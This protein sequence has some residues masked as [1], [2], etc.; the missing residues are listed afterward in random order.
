M[1]VEPIADERCPDSSEGDE[2][3][4]D[5]VSTAI[6]MAVR[7]A[8]SSGIDIDELAERLEMPHDRRFRLLLWQQ[9]ERY[10]E[11]TGQHLRI[12]RN[13][14]VVCSPAE[15][16]RE[17]EKRW[18]TSAARSRRAFDLVQPLLGS[19]DIEARAKAERFLNR[20][21][22]EQA[23][24]DATAAAHARDQSLTATIRAALSPNKEG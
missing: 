23:G 9:M 19:T 1:S 24:L 22:S 8:A 20:Q 10:R 21:V 14:V 11:E 2:E 15:Q 16:V 5:V 12:Q 3:E 4:L 6:A 17:A 18:R 7:G 13:Q